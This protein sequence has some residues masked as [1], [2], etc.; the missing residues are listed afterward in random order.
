MESAL[1]FLIVLKWS[2][3]IVLDNSFQ[4][5]LDLSQHVFLPCKQI[6]SPFFSD[7]YIAE[8]VSLSCVSVYMIKSK[9]SLVLPH[10]KAHYIALFFK[11]IVKKRL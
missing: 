1:S 3:L 9:I 5:T 6:I 7:N 11:R 8:G 4:M 10:R 2:Y